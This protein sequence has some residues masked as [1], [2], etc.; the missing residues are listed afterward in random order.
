MKDRSENPMPPGGDVI[1]RI[2][3]QPFFSIVGQALWRRQIFAS[4][5]SVPDLIL[6]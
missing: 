3:P 2:D 6:S 4:K 1:F 5:K